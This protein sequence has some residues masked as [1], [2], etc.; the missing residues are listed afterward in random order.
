MLVEKC[1]KRPKPKFPFNFL[2]QRTH[3]PYTVEVKFNALA[4]GD[5]KSTFSNELGDKL[6]FGYD[7]KINSFCMD[8]P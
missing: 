7:Y 1:F 4:N 8:H 2:E 5:F 3:V 6:F